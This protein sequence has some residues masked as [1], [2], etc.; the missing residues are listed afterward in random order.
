MW[1]WVLCRMINID[2][3]A[4]FYRQP[5]RPKHLLFVEDA[6]SHIVCFFC[7]CCFFVKNEVYLGVWVYFGVFN[8]IPLINL[9]VSICMPC[10]FY[11]YCFLV[12]LDIRYNDTSRSSF[13][14]QGCFRYRFFPYK[15]S[16]ELLF[17]CLWRIVSEFWWKLHWI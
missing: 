13:I 8:S 3:F 12:Q 7:C 15:W 17:P 6:F 16:W 10:T 9:S 2:I 11:Y 5:V 4:F 1:T 14:V